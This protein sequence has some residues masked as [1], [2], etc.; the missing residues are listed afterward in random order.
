ATTTVGMESMNMFA[1]EFKR[2]LKHAELTNMPHIGT[3]N[4]YCFPAV[5]VNILPAIAED[6]CK[7]KSLECMAFFGDDHADFDDD[8]GGGLTTM[9]A[10]SDVARRL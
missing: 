5:Q 6:E 4:N 3:Y 9:I 10:N 8:D 1:P 7:E 2:Q